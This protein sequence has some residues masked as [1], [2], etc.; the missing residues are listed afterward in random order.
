MGPDTMRDPFLDIEKSDTTIPD[1]NRNRS[2]RNRIAIALCLSLVL[3]GGAGFTFTR[4][5]EET[6]S[7]SND[8]DFV[9]TSKS[10][11]VAADHETC[12]EIG[13]DVL[14]RLD[15]S[16]VD[17]AVAVA[18]CLG[19]VNPTS[20]GI[21]GGA[22]MVVGSATGSAKAYDMRETASSTAHKDMFKDNPEK[23]EKGPLSVAVP[24]EVAGLY[25]A[26][27]NNGRRVDWKKLVEPSIKLAGEG[28]KV[29]PHLAFALST[30]EGKIR[31]DPGLKSVFVIGDK[32]LTKGDTCKNIE[33]AKTLKKVAENGMKAF[34]ED[35]V[36]KNLVNDLN[37]AGGKMT[38]DDLRKY[39]VNVT[40]AMVV[41]DVMGFK[42]QGM[43]PPSSGTPGFAMVMNILER[44]K[45]I[46]DKNLFLHRVIE[47]IKFML[48]ARMDLGDPA[49][50]EGISDVLKNMT[51]K[52]WAHNIQKK[53]SDDTT[54]PPDYYRNKYK[55]LKDQG[56][57]HF[58]V[59]DKDR[60]V[61]SM[62]TTVNYAFGSGFM[63]TST[64]IILNNQMADFSNTTD[65]SAPP[66]NYIAPNKRPLSSMM[67]LIIT[68]DN[69]LVGVIGAS[70]GIYIIPA[71][72][73]VFLNH[74][75]LKMSP[76]E[77]VKSPRVY[78]K[79]IPNKV[80]Y[81]DWIVY[82]KEHILL[83]KETQDFLKSKNH[84]LVSTTVGATVQFVVQNGQ[85]LTAVSDLRKDGK[86]AAA[87]AAPSPAPSPS[88]MF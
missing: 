15:G 69:E 53:I 86:P 8:K 11:V 20:S 66:A 73:Q 82:N 33:L 34:Y 3:L 22:F 79:L 63:S 43:W 64:G 19:V 38:L 9:V 57:S 83:K 80:L 47:A 10:G 52:G 67:P 72:I 74:F 4:Y 7:K 84:E 12:S 88:P 13:A 18:F 65:E 50:V 28:F 2:R 87:D 40:D 61:V 1:I 55:Q 24:G 60:N 5:F 77:A 41:D 54:Y 35:D 39:K 42:I 75:V 32:L 31:N 49:F 29:G 17:A 25:Q 48:A 51:S 26:W 56:T 6:E 45:D 44:Y 21:G 71:V 36:A 23:Q 14:R 76:L 27:T 37:N 78:H 58:C 16:A 30:N 59:V 68:K 62:T 85:V 81:E 46:V 70:G